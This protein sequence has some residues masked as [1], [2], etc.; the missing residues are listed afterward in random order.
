MVEDLFKRAF[1]AIELI[2]VLIIISLLISLSFQ[3]NDFVRDKELKSMMIKANNYHQ[4]V[5]VFYDLYQ[6]IPGDFSQATTVISS[7]ITYNGNGDNIIN[8]Y[9][10]NEGI[11][12][13]EHLYYAE[14]VSFLP[15]YTSNIPA[16]EQIDC[17]GATND[18][19]YPGFNTPWLKTNDSFISIAFIQGD[20]GA[21]NDMASNYVIGNGATCH[22]N[23]VYSANGVITP[24][25]AMLIYDKYYGK[26]PYEL[27]YQYNDD[28]IFFT[29][30]IIR[31]V[32]AVSGED[33][34]YQNPSSTN[35]K[36][37]YI[38]YRQKIED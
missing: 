26:K 22:N 33:C 20:F 5:Q 29:Y 9:S 10:D 27:A 18:V 24:H 38:F 11:Y 3:L 37:C 21:I 34:D 36:I 14:L 16:S 28:K 8:G 6:A 30:A 19:V 25:E 7:D 12:L 15:I 2:I 4:S 13:W 1:T 23:N 17:T 32:S 35:K 31:F